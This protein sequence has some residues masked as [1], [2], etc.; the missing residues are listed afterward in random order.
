MD[1]VLA[2]GLVVR[3]GGSNSNITGFVSLYHLNDAVVLKSVPSKFRK[4]SKLACRVLSKSGRKNLQLTAKPTLVNMNEDQVITSWEEITKQGQ[5]VTGFITKVLERTIYVTLFGNVHGAC[6]VSE[7]ENYCVGQVLQVFVRNVRPLRFCLR[8]NDIASGVLK[9]GSVVSLDRVLE[10]VGEIG[11][12]SDSLVVSVG[13][14]KA[15]LP[16]THLSDR[17]ITNTSLENLK[18]YFTDELLVVKRFANTSKHFG[19]EYMVT[20]KQSIIHQ[21]D[22]LA[23]LKQD[24][25]SSNEDALN[26]FVE[27]VSSKGMYVHFLNNVSGYVEKQEISCFDQVD[28]RELFARGDSVRVRVLGNKTP[29]NEENKT[30]TL[31]SVRSVLEDEKI[32]LYVDLGRCLEEENFPKELEIGTQVEARV[33]EIHSAYTVLSL[34]SIEDMIGVCLRKS[35]NSN[36]VKGAVVKAR[37]LHV[38]FEKRV[39][40]LTLTQLE[41]KI[42]RVKSGTSVSMIVELVTTHYAVTTLPKRSNQLA[43]IPLNRNSGLKLAI[44]ERVRGKVLKSARDASKGIPQSVL[45][46]ALTNS[47]ALEQ[48]RRSRA[49]S[50]SAQQSASS[51]VPGSEVSVQIKEVLD[52]QINVRVLGVKGY[53]SAR[54]HITNIESPPKS[55]DFKLKDLPVVDINQTFETCHVLSNKDFAQGS[56]GQR[57]ELSLVPEAKTTTD[58]WGIV[59]SVSEMN[60]IVA[61]SPTERGSL[62]LLDAVTKSDLNK[63]WRKMTESFQVGMWVPIRVIRRSGKR[64]DLALDTKDTVLNVCAIRGLN[65]DEDEHSSAISL[66]VQISR[67]EFGRVDIIDFASLKDHELVNG[68]LK[69]CKVLKRQGRMID[70]ALMR[71]EKTRTKLPKKGDQVVGYVVDIARKLVRIGRS[72]TGM[73]QHEISKI[74]LGQKVSVVVNHVKGKNKISLSLANHANNKNKRK[75]DDDV[76]NKN[77]KRHRSELVEGLITHGSVKRVE[78]WGVFVTLSEFRCDALCHISEISDDKTSKDIRL[79]VGDL[80]RCKVLKI[81]G[82]RKISIGLKQSYFESIGDDVDDDDDKEDKKEKDEDVMDTEESEE[83]E[84]EDEEEEEEEEKEEMR[85]RPT[86]TNVLSVA[87]LFGTKSDMGTE[88]DIEDEDDEEEDTKT[89]TTKLTKK[90]IERITELEENRRLLENQLPSNNEDFERLLLENPNSVYLYVQYIAFLISRTEIER[91]RQL[92]ERAIRNVN[93]PNEQAKLNLYL[94]LLNLESKFGDKQ[95]LND[96]YRR[97]CSACAPIPIWKRY[98]H[99]HIESQNHDRVENLLKMGVKKFKNEVEVWKF[100]IRYV[101]TTKKSHKEAKAL[102]KRAL[103]VLPQHQHVSLIEYL[104]KCEFEFG[105]KNRGITIFEGLITSDPK[106]WDIWSRY[107]DMLARDDDHH[108]KTRALFQRVQSQKWSSKRMK[109]LYKKWY[110]FEQ[111]IDGDVEKVAGLARQYIQGLDKKEDEEEDESSSSDSS[112]SSDSDSSDSDDDDDDD[113]EDDE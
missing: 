109:S 98:V 62:F 45:V 111:K 31:L 94:S 59:I 56:N 100:Y 18:R 101:V 30:T 53:V 106:R 16:V 7:D 83:E 77:K 81:A 87:S 47:K 6:V 49:G 15:I 74:Q 91:A 99:I 65:N 9:V 14:T 60:A 44:G 72:M 97:A 2:K 35:S 26:G 88:S 79:K 10:R 92:G 108:D 13:K 112:D 19:C 22:T 58:Q 42:R 113:D 3:V 51:V 38:D 24:S 23:L 5:Q 84:E 64:I 41:E 96:I 57:L 50:F 48:S 36:L 27:Y 1:S 28:P 52:S 46:C 34:S 105:S 32:D 69:E 73:I 90:E 55:R 61:L 11:H 4:G 68:M 39:V 89:S 93:F 78:K 85:T 71:K 29:D 80:V 43:L 33:K 63:K 8:E 21:R 107:I 70:V 110:D 82:R 67:T 25:L 102:L 75:R 20:A 40:D 95:T 54:V 103:L 66:S 104:G 86:T 76:E 37:V 17:R 12:S